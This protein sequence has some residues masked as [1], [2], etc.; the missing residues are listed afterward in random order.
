MKEQNKGVGY[1]GYDSVASKDIMRIKI[2]NIYTGQ[3]IKVKIAFV[4]TVTL[5]MNTFY[6]F[7][8]GT[9][10]TPRYVTKLSK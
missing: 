10:I 1:G 3:Q 6:E 4:H 7:R 8:L 9:T 5:V 2:G